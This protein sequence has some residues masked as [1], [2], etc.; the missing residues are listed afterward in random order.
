[1]LRKITA[2]TS[3]LLNSIYTNNKTIFTILCN[4]WSYLAINSFKTTRPY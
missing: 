2:N 4:S 1:M 3:A